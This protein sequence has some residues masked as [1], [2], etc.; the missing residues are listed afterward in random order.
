MEKM[1][2]VRY[3]DW[4]SSNDTEEKRWSK[5]G[6]K[7]SGNTIVAIDVTKKK[8]TIP[9]Y[10]TNTEWKNLW[11]L[12]CLEISSINLLA[13]FTHLPKKLILND[14]NA[15]KLDE[16]DIFCRHNVN[17]VAKIQSVLGQDG[18]EWMELNG[19]K[20]YITKDGILYTK[21]MRSLLRCPAARAGEVVIPKGVKFINE[22]AFSHCEWMPRT[23]KLGT[24]HLVQKILHDKIEDSYGIMFL[25]ANSGRCKL[26]VAAMSYIAGSRNAKLV[27]FVKENEKA[28]SN[29]LL[30]YGHIK[31]LSEFIQT[32]FVSHRTLSLMLKALEDGT[33]TNAALK[34]NPEASILHDEGKQ[35]TA[36]AY[37]LKALSEQKNKN[38]EELHIS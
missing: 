3:Q 22:K 36:K 30:A 13:Q 1:S 18:M 27:K 33:D 11:G 28:I 23:L 14:P 24:E 6:V 10:A 37:I 38:N 8:V 4:P 7:M 12:E 20:D 25:Y 29:T 19:S 9:P 21:D 34:N 35:T 15:L 26:V 31:E 32:G 16:T 5:D 2:K 17:S